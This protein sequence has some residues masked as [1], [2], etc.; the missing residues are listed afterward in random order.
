MEDM[1]I[2]SVM[3]IPYT[4]NR[5]SSRRMK[6]GDYVDK[7]RNLSVDGHVR[8][9]NSTCEGSLDRSRHIGRLVAENRHNRKY[10]KH[11]KKFLG[12]VDEIERHKNT[13]V[14]SPLK[15]ARENAHLFRKATMERS[16]NSIRDQYMD[17]GKVPFSKF[18]S[19]SSGFSEDHAILDLTEQNMHNQTPEMAFLQV[20]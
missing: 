18:H 2:D 6:R 16:M 12:S 5:L 1:D 15:N 20:G 4:L 13:I 9:S 8:G 7:E 14:L 3:D 19:R 10:Y 17:K 11:S